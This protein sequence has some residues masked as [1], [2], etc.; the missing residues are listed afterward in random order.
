MNAANISYLLSSSKA[1]LLT[2]SSHSCM[3]QHALALLSHTISPQ[4][5]SKRYVPTISW[6]LAFNS[7][8]HQFN[9]LF[10]ILK[11][12]PIDSTACL[13]HRFVECCIEL[14]T[15]YKSQSARTIFSILASSINR[16]AYFTMSATRATNE[17]DQI[18]L[19]RL[20]MWQDC[21]GG[22]NRTVIF[23]AN[24]W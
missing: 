13:N 5:V 14:N 2:I 6:T 7:I 20:E 3:I 18:S 15:L 9:S 23:A 1:R 21:V 19:A 12:L 24:L 11:L 4:R 22:F 8:C 16:A 17:Y 10:H